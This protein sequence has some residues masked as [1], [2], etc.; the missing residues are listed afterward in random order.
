MIYADSNTESNARSNTESAENTLPSSTKNSNKT[1]S[2]HRKDPAIKGVTRLAASLLPWYKKLASDK[3]YAW[4]IYLA[5]KKGDADELRDLVTPEVKHDGVLSFTATP[6]KI[7]VSLRLR[8]A[9]FSNRFD[10]R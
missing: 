5:A 6:G 1:K 8:G 10:V 2:N 3:A 7:I 4:S 9:M